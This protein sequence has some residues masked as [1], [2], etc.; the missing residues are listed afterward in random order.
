MVQI[1][2]YVLAIIQLSRIH[3]APT[4]LFLFTYKAVQYTNFADV[5]TKDVLLSI[6]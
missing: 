3:E 5:S 4:L 1:I 2:E 6:S